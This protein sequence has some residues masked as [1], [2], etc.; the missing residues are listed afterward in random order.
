MFVVEPSNLEPI[1]KDEEFILYRGRQSNGPG[2]RAVLLLVPAST[3]PALETLKKIEREYSLRDELGSAWAVRPLAVSQHRG[4]TAL[5][6]EDPGGETL[7]QFLPGPLEMTRFLRVAVGLATALSRVHQSGLIH[8]DVKPANV[9]VNSTTGEVRLMGFGIASRLPRERQTPELP[10]FIAGTLPYMAPEQT[11]RM[12]RSIDSRSDLYALG[13]TL[14][15]ML[16]GS[17]P[18]SATDPMELV[19][20][21]IARQP[22][23]PGARLKGIPSAV[24]DIVM[25]L[26]AKTAEE[27]YQTATGAA[28]DLRRCLDE[29][30][31][32]G[33]IDE[34]P[35]GE[36][37]IPDR[38]L[39]P[40]KLYGREREVDAL[41]AAFDRVVTQ[42]R[43]EFVLVSGYSG[44]GKSSLVNELHKVLVPP[45]GLFAA[46][47]FDQYKRDIP[48]ATL[49]Q[50]FETLV[51]QILV[52]RDAELGYW[53][54]A[55]QEALGSNGQLIINL[56]PEVEFLIGKQPPAPELPPQD[57]QRRFQLVFRRFVGAF[58]RPEHP[59]ALF[60]D[61]LQWLD[62]ATLE[63]LERLMTDPDLRYLML[64]GAYRD[65]EVTSSHPLTQT[66]DAIRQARA[67]MQEIVLVPLRVDD[68]DRL[69]ADALHSERNAARPL[70]Q[71]VHEKTSGNPFFAIQFLTALA[72]EGLL[73]FDPDAAAW[74]WDLARIRARRYTDNV[75]D[76]MAGKLK[77]LSATTQEALKQL[78]CLG[79]VAE[80]TTL[81]LVRGEKEEAIHTAL[82]EAVR[83]GLIFQEEST[84]KFLHDRIQEAAYAL[85]PESERAT[86]HVRIG[87]VLV[88]RMTDG[89][90]EHL[91]DVAN[92]FNRGAALVIDRDEKA[93]VASIDLRAG[94]KAKASAAY[95][96]ARAYF[97]AGMALLD[98]SD[99][100]SQYEL[101]FRLWL[102][103]AECEFLTGHF[104]EAEQLIGELLQRA[105]AKVDQADAYRLRV[106]LHLM[107]SE[108]QEAVT[109]ALTCLRGFGIDMPEHPTQEEVQAEYEAFCQTLNG[110]SIESL[111][112][113]PLMTDP[114]RRAAMQVLAV[115]LV[116]AYSTDR[117]L[118]CLHLC[119]MVNLSM[120]HGTS[121][122]S[123]HGYGYW[124]IVLGPVF[125]RYG[126]G[127]RFA[128]L[129]CDL[130]EKHGF[131]ASQGE[132]FASAALAGAWTQ[133]IAIAIDFDRKAIRAAIE[134]GDLTVACLGMYRSI[135][136]M[137]V[138]NDALDSVWRESEMALDFVRR[139]RY[140]D[141]EDIVRSQQRFIAAMQGRT[142]T[143]S[144]FNNALFDEA[145][146]EAQLTEDRMPLMIDLY[147]ILKLK[148]R[149]LSGD[150]AESLEAAGKAKQ[151]LGASADQID[152]LDYF[153]YT[154]LTVSAL[155]GTAST[156]RQQTWR[157]LLTAHREQLGEWAENNPTTFADKH[158]LVLAEIARLEGR[159]LEAMRHYEQAILLAG[160]HGFVQNEALANEIAARFYG[161]RGFDKISDLYLRE[162]RYLYARWGADGKVKQL[163]QLYPLIKEHTLA[164]GPTNSIIAP[165]EHLDLA[166]VIKVS[167][168]SSGDMVLET[169][170]DKLMRAAV[171]QAGADRGLLIVSRRDELQIEAEANTSGDELIVHL[172]DGSTAAAVMPESLVHYVM[173]TRETVILEDASSQNPFS[174]DPYI[175]QR[176]PRS[177]L[178]LP[179]INQGKLISIL[180][181]E[182]NLTPHAFTR[183]RLTVLKVLAFQAAISLENTRLYRDIEDRERRIRRLVDANILGIFIW[184]L[185]GAIVE[186]N[187]AF[188]EMLQYGHEDFVSTRVRWTELTPREW[189]ERDERALAELKATGTVHPYEK[190][191]FRKDG[192]RVPVL[193]GAALFQGVGND[194][195]AFVLDLSEQ[196]RAEAE[197]KALK[198]QLYKENLALRDEV[199]RASMFEEIVGASPALQSV[200]ARVARVGPTEST[201][202]ITGETGTGKE[203]IARAIHKRS[204]RS[205]RAFV[206]VNCAALAPS[207]ISSELFG[208]EKG[209]FTGAVQRRL[210]RF[211][212]ADGGTIFLDEVGDLPIETQV[213]LLRVLQEREF[214]RV[215]GGQPIHVDVRVV[216]ATNRDLKAAIANG[217]FRQDLFYRLNVFPIEVPS[218]RERKDDILILVEYFVRRYA[219]RAGKNIRSIDKK[220]L[221]LLQSYDW[222]GNIRE[223][224]NVIE[225]SVI[226]SAGEVFSVDELWLPKEISQPA[227]GALVPFKAEGEPRSEREVIQAALAESRGRVSGPS[228]AA[229]K[230]GIPPSTLDHR[231]KALKIIKN[232]FKFR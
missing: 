22:V 31:T 17:L 172:R 39:I 215:G 44:V 97:A 49:A 173:R 169:L 193:V 81:A 217:A 181:L 113:L 40:E 75:V 142:V 66:L 127:H 163:D 123:P 171:E 198:D 94:R 162:A 197:I 13:V 174:A 167:Q 30:E 106:Q 95:A 28:S 86:A 161:A 200:L 67:I 139:A 45:R 183:D 230:L 33:W 37:D 32:R 125:H 180:H 76:L 185:E 85:I 149:F 147:W 151:F 57:A 132:A 144:T 160:E 4:R 158:A 134:A 201:V 110:R 53:R 179:L 182:N 77:R 159:D 61:D 164:L 3:R 210:G 60:L 118:H 188:I 143:F 6:F 116:P 202:L 175:I 216:A 72:D 79:N 165:S 191:Y 42:G 73:R 168:A 71:L 91:F 141:V 2:S 166:T 103:R 55:L 10:E 140:R 68:V 136:D 70:A 189:H 38:L 90:A 20:C 107:K 228:G 63:L 222:P 43:P 137:L 46:G 47:K 14:Y 111:I 15:E 207:L 12:N 23:P 130:V 41:L 133:P 108:N 98:E 21:H 223:L 99:W 128:K 8:K 62:P 18:F 104:D 211:E 69:V 154:A 29:W 220:T 59:L 199:V 102:E 83:A 226:L 121:G 48:Y 26:L 120:Q 146:F 192:S 204:P 1:R 34:F 170:I 219:R 203:L 56:V 190:E 115:L 195:V 145:I 196:K 129:A 9:L 232:Q 214:E 52:K 74:I 138:R 100:S 80:V 177:I 229:A 58:A 131:V 208:H 155:Y 227:P 112:D 150:Y 224:Q 205:G 84:Y 135:T 109:A 87:R 25:K 51:R 225:R 105:A 187:E 54:D 157:E 88:A 82:W 19:H 50:A 117:R 114:E 209:A 122:D 124:G 156:D 24:S 206:S 35:F 96:S 186:A 64:V 16:T 11:G 65:N 7:D 213:A 148:A 231:I 36:Q 78:A 27:R 92:Q 221:D 152:Q 194:G 5:V 178:T 89:L 218:L 126:E 93:R 119:R 153:F 184:D 176:R 212:M 101:T